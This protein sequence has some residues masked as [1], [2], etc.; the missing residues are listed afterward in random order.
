MVISRAY[1]LNRAR[2]VPNGGESGDR[3]LY[4]LVKSF[5]ERRRHIKIAQDCFS[6]RNIKYITGADIEDYLDDIE[7]IS[8]KTRHNYASSLKDFFG[9]VKKIC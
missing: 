1:C 7:D 4:Q 2:W 6:D 9:W 3:L 8:E 5:K